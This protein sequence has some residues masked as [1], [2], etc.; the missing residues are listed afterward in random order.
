M[1]EL[2][3]LPG[4][5][6]AERVVVKRWEAGEGQALWALLERHGN[7]EWLY[8]S[9]E[10]LVVLTSVDEMEA[11]VCRLAAMWMTRERFVMGIWLKSNQQCIG[12]LWIEP[13]R[14]EVLSFELGWFLD[15]GYLGQGL[16]AEAAKRSLDFL[17]SE[18]QAHKVIVITRDTNPKSMKLAERIGVR[19]EGHFR[20]CRI[21]KGVRYGLVY[22]GLLKTE[23]SSE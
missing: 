7:R 14:W 16:A 1:F 13:Q 9:A 22:Y 12:E 3:V 17:F 10:E 8:P 21:E 15:Q 18:L 11:R 2:L 5:L 20:E 23:Y 4:R 19:K 6:E